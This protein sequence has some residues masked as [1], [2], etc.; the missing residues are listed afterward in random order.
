LEID[1]YLKNI[2]VKIKLKINKQIEMGQK[3]K[4]LPLK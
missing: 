4:V 1:A 3:P 2:D